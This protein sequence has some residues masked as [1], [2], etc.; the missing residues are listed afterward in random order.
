MGNQL[1][2]Y[3]HIFTGL[4]L[5][6]FSCFI[7]A[8]TKTA[9]ISISANIVPACTAGTNVSGSTSFGTLDFGTQYQLIQPVAVT[10]Q[11][12]SGAIAVQC[13]AGVV[14]KVVMNAGNS[15]NV[16]QRYM[17]GT[18]LTRYVLYNLYTDAAHT[19]IWDNLTGVSKTATGLAESLPV[20]GLVPVQT[21]P[22]TD[23]YTDAITVTVSW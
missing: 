23:S 21:T 4:L 14:Y 7:F 12:N 20:Y 8:S 15:G 16:S 6:I 5:P 17:Q 19:T 1:L 11:T 3:H 18:V 9:T 2:K 10:G 22:A 13:A